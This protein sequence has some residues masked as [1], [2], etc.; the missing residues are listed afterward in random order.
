MENEKRIGG[1]AQSITQKNPN[2]AVRSNKCF[3]TLL[4]ESCFTDS[5]LFYYF[6]LF[7]FLK[8]DM[9]DVI[10]N[11]STKQ[12]VFLMCQ[13]SHI[14]VKKVLEHAGPLGPTQR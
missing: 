6:T 9:E 4:K 7:Y 11:W 5:F 13:C 12:H 8:G 3:A 10:I 2:F 14:C 1:G